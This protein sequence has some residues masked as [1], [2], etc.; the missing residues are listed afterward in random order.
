[1]DIK[2]KFNTEGN[3]FINEL[4][5]RDEAR[6]V[7]ENIDR[8]IDSKAD[9]L[10]VK[11]IHYSEGEINTIHTLSQNDSFFNNLMHHKKIKNIAE[12]VLGGDVEPQWVQYFAKPAKVGLSSP[13]HQDNFYWCVNPCKTITFWI[14]LSEITKDMAPLIYYKK[15]HLLGKIQHE[16]SFSPGSSQKVRDEILETL[17]QENKISYNYSPGD[18]SIHHGWSVHGS[19]ANLSNKSRRGISIWYKEKSAGYNEK[20]LLKYKRNLDF[21]LKQK[22]K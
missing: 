18:A 14:S 10:G 4:L 15:S 6:E 21:Q 3:A 8:F 17:G 20:D 22:N 16:N 5:T 9:S 7:E 2:D 1:L 11:E 13:F 19:E 12:Q